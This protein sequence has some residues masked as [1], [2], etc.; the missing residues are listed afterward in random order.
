MVA[1][2]HEDFEKC[3]SLFEQV[4]IELCYHDIGDNGHIV[5]DPADDDV[6]AECLERS[7]DDRDHRW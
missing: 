3:L 7:G 1:A 5:D 4:C 2:G 6:A